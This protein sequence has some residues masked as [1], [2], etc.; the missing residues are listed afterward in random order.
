M[1][2][3]VCVCMHVMVE[4]QELVE[5][6]FIIAHKTIQSLSLLSAGINPSRS[7]YLSLF[8]PLSCSLFLYALLYRS[9]SLFLSH[10]HAATKTNLQS[11]QIQRQIDLS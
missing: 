8:F 6:V 10:M 1:C 4:I 11:W 5:L 7:S 9:L 2:V 3:C